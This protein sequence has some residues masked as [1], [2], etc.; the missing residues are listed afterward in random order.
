MRAG[1]GKKILSY[2]VLV[3]LLASLLL[4]L[5]LRFCL[6]PWLES[7]ANTRLAERSGELRIESVDWSFA[8]LELRVAGYSEPGLELTGAAVRIPWRGWTTRGRPERVELVLESL[9]IETDALT[10]ADDAPVPPGV[11]TA[12]PAAFLADR[13]G[14]LASALFEVPVGQLSLRCEQLVIEAGGWRE[15]LRVEGGFESIGE[16]WARAVI[17]IEG[18]WWQS[19]VEAEALSE[20]LRLGLNYDATL[21]DTDAAAKRIEEL[22]REVLPSGWDLFPV[23]FDEGEALA[24]FSGYLRWTETDARAVRMAS[25]LN[26]GGLEGYLPQ[27]D[28]LIG[29]FSAGLA[30]N[31]RSAPKLVAT[32]PLETL[33]LNGW[34]TGSGGLEL[35]VEEERGKVRLRIGEALSADLELEPV[36]MGP[37]GRLRVS[38]TLE[39]G[40]GAGELLAALYPDA[41][42]WTLEGNLRPRLDLDLGGDRPRI[43]DFALAGDFETISKPGQLEGSGAEF[44]FNTEGR[45]AASFRLRSLTA[46][47]LTIRDLRLAGE[48]TAENALRVEELSA[49]TLGGGLRAGG[50]SVTRG[51]AVVPDSI[52]VRLSS[53]ETSELAAIVPQFRGEVRGR[54]S[55]ELRVGWAGEPVLL[56]GRLDLDESQPDGEARLSY[57]VDG[58]LTR[59]I[60]PK[61]ASYVQY[62]RAELALENLGLKRFQLEFFPAD[63]RRRPVRLNFF[64]ESRQADLVVPIDFTLNVNAEESERLLSLLQAM[65]QG[66]LELSR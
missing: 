3:V 25:L 23:P 6:T 16:E 22:T 52:T 19:R 62:R 17:R 59:G 41:G 14:P 47:G 35:S 2:L 24:V 12:D 60:D 57:P 49:R 5:A 64:G 4:V 43:R 21:P 13:L 34:E 58:L 48:R 10:A 7:Y 37:P 38:G 1:I 40:E 31:G 63:D 9:R 30:I 66:E 61:S 51:G 54:I 28:F 55:G 26:L 33:F 32:A 39:P 27:G 53:I 42:G 15:R 46:G 56:G 45:G 44:S 11:G 8:G 50:F 36:T 18:E 65:Q 20:P 29:G